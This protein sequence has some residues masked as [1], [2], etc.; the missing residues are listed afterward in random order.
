MTNNYLNKGGKI[1]ANVVEQEKDEQ[2][3][4]VHILCKIS[5]KTVRVGPKPFQLSMLI[6]I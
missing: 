4:V 5:V 6:Q 3:I 1:P 2:S